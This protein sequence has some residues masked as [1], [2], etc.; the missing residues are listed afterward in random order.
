VGPGKPPQGDRRGC[1]GVVFALT[2]TRLVTFLTGAHAVFF[3]GGRENRN[4]P[5]SALLGPALDFRP[6]A[7]RAAP[8]PLVSRTGPWPP[9]LLP[10]PP[11]CRLSLCLA[12]GA[13]RPCGKGVPFFRFGAAG[14]IFTCHPQ[15]VPLARPR[16]SRQRPPA[17]SKNSGGG[18]VGR[19]WGGT[20]IGPFGSD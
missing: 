9:Q 3:L 13:G 14:Q 1:W 11:V 8:P 6:G 16:P 2:C 5:R 4:W 7:R 17:T 18:L 15:N 19:S 12:S 10:L 20:K